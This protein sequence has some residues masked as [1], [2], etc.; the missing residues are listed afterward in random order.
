MNDTVGVRDFRSGEAQK[1]NF[2]YP[3]YNT[4]RLFVRQ[5]FGFGGE[6]EKL[7]SGPTSLQARWTSRG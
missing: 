5:T 1:S 4:S 7:A 3:H 2:P 6:Q